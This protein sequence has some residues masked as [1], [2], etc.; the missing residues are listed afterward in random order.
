MTRTK[1]R[2]SIKL[3]ILDCPERSWREV[4]KKAIK[5]AEKVKPNNANSAFLKMV[6]FEEDDEDDEDVEDES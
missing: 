6:S 5:M 3:M 1:S 2:L 4:T